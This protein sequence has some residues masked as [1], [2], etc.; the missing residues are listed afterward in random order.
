M[1]KPGF[2]VTVNDASE[3]KIIN[4]DPPETAGSKQAAAEPEAGA[5]KKGG[6]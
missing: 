6:K 5:T 2:Q 4:N 3:T 1:E